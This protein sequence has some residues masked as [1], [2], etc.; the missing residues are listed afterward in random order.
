MTFFQVVGCFV[1][2][3]LFVETTLMVHVA[4]VRDSR[5]GGGFRFSVELSEAMVRRF[6]PAKLT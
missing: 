6:G 1:R 5:V 2:V 4:W 3:C